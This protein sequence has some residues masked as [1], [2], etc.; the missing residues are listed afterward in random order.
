MSWI[1]ANVPHSSQ[2]WPENDIGWRELMQ[3]ST[4][5]VSSAHVLKRGN[6]GVMYQQDHQVARSRVAGNKLLNGY[7]LARLHTF[8]AAA[9]HGS[10]ALAADEL[11]L[12]PSAVSHRIS[13]LEEDLGF[14]LFQRFH[15]KVAL[16]ADGQR[17]FWALNR[18]SSSTR[19]SWRSAIRSCRVP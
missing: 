13:A 8:E 16:T 1:D 14:K 3:E 4:F 5:S 7:Q 12:S 10:F 6:G 15:R 19:R 9:R 11:A 2:Y 18:W 17:V